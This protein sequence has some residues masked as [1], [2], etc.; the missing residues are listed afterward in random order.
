MRAFCGI[1]LLINVSSMSFLLRCQRLL[2]PKSPILGDF[3][4]GV[5]AQSPL[6]VGDL[7]GFPNLQS[8]RTAS[9]ELTFNLDLSTLMDNKKSVGRFLVTR[10]PIVV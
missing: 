9:V 3:E 8:Q 10:L 1:L 7:G 4:N 5:L 2:P 6:R